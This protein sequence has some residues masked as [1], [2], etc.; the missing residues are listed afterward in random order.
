MGA[1]KGWW[2]AGVFEAA[3]IPRHCR[4][5]REDGREKYIRK[6]GLFFFDY[7]DLT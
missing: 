5:T 2:M 7:Y 4:K 1:G 6:L 3:Q